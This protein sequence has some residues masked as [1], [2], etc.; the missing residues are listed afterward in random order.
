MVVLAASIP[1]DDTKNAPKDGHNQHKR[2]AVDVASS[3]YA[4]AEKENA[5]N[6]K[7]LTKRD[8]EHQISADDDDDTKRRTVRDLPDQKVPSPSNQPEQRKTRDTKQNEQP[9]KTLTADIPKGENP[10]VQKREIAKDESKKHAEDTDEHKINA[11]AVDDKSGDKH[12]RE[13]K[14]SKPNPTDTKKQPQ[15]KSTSAANASGKH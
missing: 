14:D 4:Y 9:K 15:Q 1:L 11:R 12:K 2:Y 13:T 5:E 3:A 7:H 8:T 10:H 6:K